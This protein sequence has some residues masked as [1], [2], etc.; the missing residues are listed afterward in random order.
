MEKEA[1]I[2]E[3]ATLENQLAALETQI[4]SLAMDV[5][6]QKTMVRLDKF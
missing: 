4:N 5:D 6:K 1:V 2:Q 3:H